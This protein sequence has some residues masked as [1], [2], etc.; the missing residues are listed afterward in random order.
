MEDN[1]VVTENIAENNSTAITDTTISSYSKQDAKQDGKQLTTNGKSE[2][3]K[4]DNSIIPPTKIPFADVIKEYQS[5]FDKAVRKAVETGIKNDR[6]KQERLRNSELT[7]EQKLAGQDTNRQVE[8]LLAENRKKD[9]EVAKRLEQIEIRE[10][11]IVNLSERKQPERL[12]NLFKFK[13]DTREEIQEKLD[14]LSEF[15]IYPKGDVEKMIADERSKLLRTY[16]PETHT[17]NKALDN[18]ERI[19]AKYEKRIK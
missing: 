17:G 11:T 2:I 5:D 12:I 10:E 18:V 1:N 13:D 6:E 14:L 3:V 16:R 4:D 7:L 19:A 9:E 15:E 8:I